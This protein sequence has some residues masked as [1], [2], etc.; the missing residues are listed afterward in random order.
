MT[1][2]IGVRLKES[3]LFLS[4]TLR[5][6]VN[7]NA[8]ILEVETMEAQKIRKIRTEVMMATAGIG[9]QGHACT[10]LI[11]AII[12]NDK[13]IPTEETLECCFEI[14]N[15]SRNTFIKYNR[16][17][18][19]NKMAALIGGIDDISRKP[20]LYMTHSDDDFKMIERQVV[21][22]GV[23]PEATIIESKVIQYLK[24]YPNENSE[25]YVLAFA[26]ILRESVI[27]SNVV[28]QHVI[29]LE[30]RNDFTEMKGFLNE[31]G[32]GI[33]MPNHFTF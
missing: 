32:V 17:A 27:G 26:K 15:F 12:G 9:T 5:N 2:L 33:P 1:I 4:D 20:Y 7:A 14:L 31:H 11:R 16:H 29:F 28:G 23:Q 8:T 19:Y 10:E 3:V 13:V 25:N 24:D 18:E 22:I 30:I 21:S 6:K